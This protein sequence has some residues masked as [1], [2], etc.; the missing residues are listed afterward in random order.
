ML[1]VSAEMRG[2][3]VGRKLVR[4]AEQE[5]IRRGCRCVWLD[6]FS[7]QARGSYERLGYVMFGIINDYPTG[8]SRFFLKQTIA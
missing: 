1:F 4:Q 3:G 2:Q 7:F 8:H 6:T 5:A